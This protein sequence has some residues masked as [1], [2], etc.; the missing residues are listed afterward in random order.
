M[1]LKTIRQSSGQRAQRGQDYNEREREG[2]REDEETENSQG[3]ARRKG[4]YG[5]VDER[6]DHWRIRAGGK[7][8]EAAE[9]EM[10]MQ[11]R[12]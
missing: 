6:R 2:E 7:E 11:R 9:K 1:E 10:R 5:Q 3:K 12:R 8:D 4:M